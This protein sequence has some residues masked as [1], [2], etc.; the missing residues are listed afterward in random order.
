M[1]NSELMRA[2]LGTLSDARGRTRGSAACWRQRR[3][4]IGVRG[5]GWADRVRERPDGAAV[6]VRPA[7]ELVGQP[8]ELLVPDGRARGAPGAPDRVTSPIR[9]RGRWARGWSWP[10]GAGDGTTFPAEISRV[11]PV[12]FG[13]GASLPAGQRG[14]RQSAAIRERL[15]ARADRERP[16]ARCTVGQ[17]LEGLGQ[18][19]SGVAHVL[20]PAAPAK[21]ARARPAGYRAGPAGGS[22]R[23]STS[24]RSSRTSS[25]TWPPAVQSAQRIPT[26]LP[27]PVYT[28]AMTSG[29]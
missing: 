11:R 10:G 28:N 16:G 19:T 12:T 6:R 3:T 9:G 5:R 14:T 24:R 20:G 7:T 27:I 1:I 26:K 29:S 4:C 18:L 22:P 2:L 25:G 8:V 15:R 13:G 21:A 23:R 17:R